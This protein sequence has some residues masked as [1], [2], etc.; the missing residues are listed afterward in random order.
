MYTY[1]NNRGLVI[2]DIDGKVVSPCQSRDDIDF[3]EYNDWVEAGNEP[4]VVEPEVEELT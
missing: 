3:I 4:T 2:R 1:I